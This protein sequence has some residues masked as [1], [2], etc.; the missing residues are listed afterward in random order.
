MGNT[1]GR[2]LLI[3]LLLS[4]LTIGVL[5]I[6]TSAAAV[7]CT[8]TWDGEG[9]TDDWEVAANWAGDTLPTP[10]DNVCVGEGVD[11]TISSDIVVR[12]FQQFSPG[13]LSIYKGA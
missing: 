3:H 13:S 5:G 10:S 2:H 6:A 8:R 7:V 9:S 11:A 12:G 1:R 4:A